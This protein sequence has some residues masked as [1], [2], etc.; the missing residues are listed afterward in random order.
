MKK[1]RIEL[2]A[3]GLEAFKAREHL[4]NRD[5][6]RALG[7]SDNTVSRLIDG[8]T[9]VKLP[10]DTLWKIELIAKEGLR[11]GNAGGNLQENP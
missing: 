7:I 3:D 8:D 1:S 4:S 10:V 11:S 9:S 2:L 6:G 5:I